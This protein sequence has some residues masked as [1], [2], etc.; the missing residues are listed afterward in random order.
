LKIEPASDT[1]LAYLKRDGVTRD[2]Q[3]AMMFDAANGQVD[4]ASLAQRCKGDRHHFRFIIGP[5]DAAE[6]TDLKA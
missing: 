6:M 2:G 4:G 1:H 3:N 5:E